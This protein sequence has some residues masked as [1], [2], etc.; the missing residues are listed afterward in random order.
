[1][2]EIKNQFT[3]GKMN[4]DVDERLVPK[5]EYRDAVNVQVSTSDD[6]DVGT[7]QNLLGNKLVRWVDSNAAIPISIQLDPNAVCV[8]SISDEKNDA[9]YWFV[10]EPGRNLI[11]EY[12]NNEINPVFV[13]YSIPNTSIINSFNLSNASFDPVNGLIYLNATQG[14]NNLPLDYSGI[15]VGD[16]VSFIVSTPDL[17]PAPGSVAGLTPQLPLGVGPNYPSTISTAPIN[18]L[19]SSYYINLFITNIDQTTNTITLNSGFSNI[20]NAVNSSFNYVVQISPVESVLKF[21]RDNDGNPITI[22]SINIIDD[23]LFWTD[24][25]NEPKKLNITSGK[26]GTLQDGSLQTR[27]VNSSQFDYLNSNTPINLLPLFEEKHL[28]VLKKAPKH[29]LT[30]ETFTRDEFAFGQTITDNEFSEGISVGGASNIPYEPGNTLQLILNL[31][32]NSIGSYGNIP[33]SV[34]DVL[35]LNSINTAQSPQDQPLISV[36][37]EQ[38]LPNNT[39]YSFVSSGSYILVQVTIISI[40]PTVFGVLDIY[41]WAVEVENKGKKFKNKFP[42]FSYR[43]KYI[44]GEYST[45]APFTNVIFEPG[46][47]VYQVKEAYNLG[48]ENTLTKIVLKNYAYNLPKDVVAVDLLYKESNSPIVYVI[49]TV[50]TE[51]FH[52]TDI[53]NEINI[54]HGYEIKPNMVTTTLPENQLLRSWDVVPRTALAQEVI[55]SRIVYG[56]YLQNYNLE[57][58]I[59][60]AVLKD[61]NDFDF[62]TNFKSLKSLRNYSFGI[63]YLDQ[64][65]RQTPVFTHKNADV[66]IQIQNSHTQNQIE[67]TPDIT[68]P[69]WATHYKVFVK[70]TSNEYFNLAMDRI[71]DA[72][73]GNV[74]IAFPS[75]DRNKVDEETFLILKKGTDQDDVV[76]DDNKYK[77]LAIANEAP[78]FIKTKTIRLGSSIPKIGP[79]GGNIFIQEPLF[80]ADE[81]RINIDTF[82]TDFTPLDE[83]ERPMSVRFEDPNNAQRTE[84]YNIT[85]IVK[86]GGGVTSTS[87]TTGATTITPH[88]YYEVF[89]DRPIEEDYVNANVDFLTQFF[90]QEIENR[91][92]FDGR[93]FAK[94]ARNPLLNS[95]ILDDSLLSTDLE[96]TTTGSM[97]FYLISDNH[98]NSQFPINN[99]GLTSTQN[100]NTNSGSGT[101]WNYLLGN[102]NAGNGFW[103]IDSAYYAGEYKPGYSK[104]FLQQQ[105]MWKKPKDNGKKGFL[106]NGY[107]VTSSSCPFE[108]RTPGH[109]Q[110]VYTDSAGNHFID[111]SFGPVF[112][113]LSSPDNHPGND[114]SWR[115]GQSEEYLEELTDLENA[116]DDSTGF[117]IYGPGG[118]I[119][120]T[121][122]G[123]FYRELWDWTSANTIINTFRVGSSNNDAHEDQKDIH[124]N[125]TRPGQKFKFEGSEEIYEI[126]STEISYTLNA[127]DTKYLDDRWEL[128]IDN[129]NA[130]N[131]LTLIPNVGDVGILES[132]VGEMLQR[133]GRFGSKENKRVTYRVRVNKNPMLDTTVNGFLNTV[134]AM[135]T[136][137]APQNQTAGLLRFVEPNFATIDEQT[138][139]PYPAVWETEPKQDVGLDIYH[140]VDGTFPMYIDNENNYSFAP[141]GSVVTSSNSAFPN[142]NPVEP[143]TVVV[144]WDNNILEVNNLVTEDNNQAI[145]EFHRPD[146]STV[147]SRLVSLHNPVAGP[148]ASSYKLYIEPVVYDQPVNLS[149]FNCY[150]FGNG[151]ESNR[152]RDDFNQVII[153][154]GAKASSTTEE[155]YEEEQRKYGLIY[156][157]LYNSISGVN[158]LNQFIAA[159]KI[160]KDINPIY[161]SIQKLH[162]RDSDLVTLCEDKVL[163]ILANKDAVFNAD[164]NPQLTANERVL[165]QTIPFVGEYGIS[166][167]PESFASEAYRA[168]FTD[169]VRG[170]VMRLSMDGLTPISDHG[171]K[172]WFRDNLK[173]SNKLIGSYDDKKDEYN[174]TLDNSEDNNPKTV[175]FKENVKGW[176]SF[177]SFIPESAVSCANEYYTFKNGGLWQ[178]HVES[179]DRNTFY[180]SHSSE[181]WTRI[182]TILNDAPGSIKS[183]N[184]VNYEGSKSRV[185]TNLQD[186]QYYNLSDRDGWYV[187]AVVTDKESGNVDEFIEK[188][189]K[190]FNYIK[191]KNVQLV[192]DNILIDQ[193]GESSWDQASFA[194][195]GL[196]IIGSAPTPV[197]LLGCTDSTAIN[198]DASAINDD[199]SCIYPIDGCTFASALNFNSAANVDDNSCLWTGCTDN[200]TFSF[201]PGTALSGS[202]LVGTSVT[203]NTMTNPTNFPAE[204]YT[205]NNGVGIVDDGSCIPTELGCTDPLAS[206]YNANANYDDGSCVAVSLGCTQST[207]DNFNSLVNT[208]DGSCYW[209]GCTEPLASNFFNSTFTGILP[210]QS[211]GYSAVGA[212]AGVIDDGSCLGGGCTT[213]NSTNFDPTA[214]YNDGSCVTCDFTVTPN[215]STGGLSTGQSGSSIGFANY[216]GI[217]VTTSMLPTTQANL[218]NGQIAVTFNAAAPYLPYT[219]T[220]TDSAGN[221][222]FTQ[223]SNSN[224]GGVN[225]PSSTLFSNLPQGDYIITATGMGS[226]SDGVCQYQTNTITVTVNPVYVLGCMDTLACNYDSTATSDDGSCEY[227]TCAGCMDTAANGNLS[228]HNAYGSQ[229]NSPTQSCKLNGNIL[230]NAPCTIECGNGST[231][232]PQG[233]GCCNYTVY[234]CN[235][236]AANNF[237]GNVTSNTTLVNDGSCIYDVLGCT[238][239]SAANYNPLATVDDGSCSYITVVSGCMDPNAE[240]YNANATN[241]TTSATWDDNWPCIYSFNTL[242]GNSDSSYGQV[243]P[244]FYNIIG[245]PYYTSSMIA[246]TPNYNKKLRHYV[247]GAIW[248]LTTAAMMDTAIMA[249]WNGP[250]VGDSDGQGGTYGWGMGQAFGGNQGS[251]SERIEITLL[252]ADDNSLNNTPTNLNFISTGLMVT[253]NG[254]NTIPHA[255]DWSSYDNAMG[256]RTYDGNQNST[257]FPPAVLGTGSPNS[258]GTNSLTNNPELRV[259]NFAGNK[260]KYKIQ[261]TQYHYIDGV[262]TAHVD[263]GGV[264]EIA[265]LPCSDSPHAVFGCTDPAACNY[266]LNAT[267]DDGSCNFP[268]TQTWVNDPNNGCFE[269]SDCANSALPPCGT[270]DSNGNPV[271]ILISPCFQ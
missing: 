127:F 200:S 197:P 234:A 22:T 40:P 25:F 243:G 250:Q 261:V 141:I 116:F 270:L 104:T 209:S 201:V 228:G 112:A 255:A 251:G 30:V 24:G 39:S 219:Y 189:G 260:M 31:D 156:S 79:S 271:V 170:K 139:S 215:L 216:S 262:Y 142:Y 98:A 113:S 81:F 75:S 13:D 135:G 256:R 194:I 147:R 128:M 187:D 87:S 85:D 204:A 1:M 70:E 89:L 11:L 18:S 109:R 148:L 90:R 221:S 86:G 177:K 185:V 95:Y 149:F 58:P 9:L 163:K 188:E 268:S 265:D 32:E 96:Y 153:D 238:D 101:G 5:G 138:V 117:P 249:M 54:S 162:S 3:G 167:N 69:D 84:I 158:N 6:S 111:I 15:N 44:D 169:K 103:F 43:Y 67:F 181:D 253:Y 37:V 49:D 107:K 247:L 242:M 155:K 248:P 124:L 88:V 33:I 136:A 214:L 62:K 232:Q 57:N 195:Q 60:N 173:F 218:S 220:I 190:W 110:G 208:D 143:E 10:N 226:P 205:Y 132:D 168:Y 17:I 52:N 229:T 45:F 263:D 258:Y 61:R 72:A 269:C 184:T 152:I 20:L 73:D 223:T 246:G 137:G 212:G 175:T 121:N 46:E 241:G 129:A 106:P 42:R 91:P 68:P 211:V 257:P 233:N 244:V 202:T 59:V 171:M 122:A 240:N 53:L 224:L 55:G 94:I 28:T 192:G 27:L 99:T 179:V 125:L 63:S 222:S 78:T 114:G 140:E 174:I 65:G 66:E 151:V 182:T 230:V 50:V 118:S 266:D 227:S 178:H 108:T 145:L 19:G 36:E 102:V 21:P 126:I 231:S 154:K 254:S 64:Y 165:G 83:F 51:D 210:P 203:V 134:T 97:S 186:D 77:I 80:E 157:G 207:A 100:L 23:M 144:S 164:G 150:S 2:P 71:Y 4:K 264:F 105:G 198:Y 115:R 16:Y 131:P 166:K 47:F 41:D 38:V 191:G 82:N 213:P 237:Y 7:V 48:M 12:K 236:P 8:A 56:N 225:D 133:M 119:T 130:T 34:G 199:G 14:I 245:N 196:G 193:E 146:G 123:A 160:T 26:L 120:A 74:W 183:F 176:V 267:C 217:P 172:N 76:I 259:Y 239:V 35:L 180:G 206:N 161:G 29:V 92:E 235:D 159:E 252:K 93:F